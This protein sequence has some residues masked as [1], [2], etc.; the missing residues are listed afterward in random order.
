[1]LIRGSG[2]IDDIVMVDTPTTVTPLDEEPYVEE[3]TIT[4]NSFTYGEVTS[5]TTGR[6][7]LDRNL[8]ASKP[9]SSINDEACYG[10]YYQWGRDADGHEKSDSNDTTI[11][12]I[13]IDTVSSEFVRANSDWTSD[14][15]DG[16]DREEKWLQTDGDS[17]CPANYKV[18]TIEQL[19]AETAD[20][21]IHTSSA[22]FNSFLKLPFA[23]FRQTIDVT[24]QG[25]LHMWSSSNN[26]TTASNLSSTP[27][28]IIENDSNYANGF[29]IRCI[30]NIIKHNG[31]AYEE[32]KSPITDRT[33]LDR[34][35][36]ASR[37]CTRENDTECYGDYYQWGR[38]ANGHEKS[39]SE[40][41][42]TQA[43]TIN[44]SGSE[45][46]R[47]HL[48]WT[49]ADSAG[50]ARGSK[51]LLTNGKSICPVDYRV[52]MIS[53]FEAE[54]DGIKTK[55]IAFESPLKIPFAGFR[56]TDTITGQGHLYM[57]SSSWSLSANN[58]WEFT[59]LPYWQRKE[60][61]RSVA[62]PIRCIKN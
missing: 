44:D 12:V 57:W 47:Y 35:L 18:P 20:Q 32:V 49:S 3:G 54:K 17:V 43:T 29:P 52:A 33:W 60:V 40:T 51:W 7:W 31:F 46:I 42:T 25:Y 53:E 58:S 28:A 15:S 48:D 22:A 9:C 62:T 5:P 13:S 1:M 21:N 59:S 55:T 16:S 2:R 27:D 37:V 26:G 14:D 41:T 36:G 6:V 4:H 61:Q 38:D 50:N 10:D 23:G 56:Q 24:G 39:S 11:Q 34:N 8:G 30:K 19:L 45:F